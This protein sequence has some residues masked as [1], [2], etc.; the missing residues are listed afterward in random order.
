LRAEADLVAPLALSPDSDGQ[1]EYGHLRGT[2]GHRDGGTPIVEEFAID[3]MAEVLKRRSFQVDE[4]CEIVTRQNIAWFIILPPGARETLVRRGEL[5][6]S[7]A[8]RSLDCN[9][10]DS[11]DRTESKRSTSVGI[12][13]HLFR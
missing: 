12:R 9:N 8:G 2:P 5:P 10:S 6:D 7:N 1:W 13:L 3:D 11:Q 4:P